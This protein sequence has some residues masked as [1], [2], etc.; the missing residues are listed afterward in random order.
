M[1]CYVNEE[2]AELI[3]EAIKKSEYKTQK[4]FADKVLFIKDRGWGH[5]LR[6]VRKFSLLEIDTMK[7][8]LSEFIDIEV[9]DEKIIITKK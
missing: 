2:Q 4:E 9:E 1:G 6:G 5:K 7:K 8:A 3:R